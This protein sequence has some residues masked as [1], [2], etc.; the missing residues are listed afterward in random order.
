MSDTDFHAEPRTTLDIMRDLLR[1]AEEHEWI[2]VDHYCG[3]GCHC[4]EGSSSQCPTC[5]GVEPNHKEGC[6]TH[7]LFKEMDAFIRVEESLQEEAA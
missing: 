2:V 4:S 7:A 1:V 3:R 5:K 6:Q